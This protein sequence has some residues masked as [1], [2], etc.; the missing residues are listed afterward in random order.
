MIGL[1]GSIGLSILHAFNGSF[2]TCIEV[3]GQ[4]LLIFF[5]IVILRY[6]GVSG[7]LFFKMTSESK[8]GLPISFKKKRG[9]G[10]R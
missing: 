8:R 4:F 9:N 6:N 2:E 5:L 7:F 3:V 10:N 1:A